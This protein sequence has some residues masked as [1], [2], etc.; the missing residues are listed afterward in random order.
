MKLKEFSKIIYADRVRFVVHFDNITYVPMYEFNFIHD[1]NSY[2]DFLC[3]FKTFNIDY[4]DYD[5]DCLIVALSDDV[6]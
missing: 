5:K 4:I 6:E 3:D 2:I 1:N